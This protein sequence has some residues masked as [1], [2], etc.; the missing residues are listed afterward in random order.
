MPTRMV[1]SSAQ[2]EMPLHTS[3]YNE[4]TIAL[5]LC[6]VIKFTFNQYNAAFLCE[7]GKGHDT[8]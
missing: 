3:Y 7:F 4:Q 1:V 5:G 2:Y 8:T 6:H